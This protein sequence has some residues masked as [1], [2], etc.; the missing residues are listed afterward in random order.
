[1][2]PVSF[3]KTTV[4]LL[5]QYARYVEIHDDLVAEPNQLVEGM[6]HGF[7]DEHDEFREYLYQ[8]R[9]AS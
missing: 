5:Q 1:M 6:I 3:N 8:L 9:R 7:L 4:D 2:I